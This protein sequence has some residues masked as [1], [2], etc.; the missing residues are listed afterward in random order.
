MFCHGPPVTTVQEGGFMYVSLSSLLPLMV[1]VVAAVTLWQS[2][3]FDWERNANPL[4]L[5]AFRQLTVTNMVLM[6][7]LTVPHVDHQSSLLLFR[8][9]MGVFLCL[10]PPLSAFGWSLVGEKNL[11]AERMLWVLAVAGTFLLVIDGGTIVADHR[12]AL[13][14][15]ETFVP[16]PAYVVFVGVIFAAAALGIRA[17]YLGHKRTVERQ[18]NRFADITRAWTLMASITVL[19]MN[20]L[21]LVNFHVNTI[22][23]T[24]GIALTIQL[25]FSME[26]GRVARATTSMLTLSEQQRGALEQKLTRDELT[27]LYTRN[28]GLTALQRAI[29]EHPAGA[30]VIFLDV[31]DFHSWNAKHGHAT[32]DRVLKGL[33]HVL[34]SSTREVDVCARYA[35][36]EFFVVLPGETAEVAVEVAERIRT[37]LEKM[38][39]PTEEP[40]RASLGVAHAVVGETAA[41][42]VDRADQSALRAKRAGKNRVETEGP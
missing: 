40:V 14:G 6:A 24:W 7:L 8:L 1:L 29:D 12:T 18:S 22:S 19:G 9:S 10:L 13:F 16:G 30:S 15:F 20:E 5:R 21:L 23:T 33:A 42:A 2:Q 37:G 32:G 25:W 3:F 4:V 35:G 41:A 26:V 28:H 31:D 17:I 27:G 11:R 38:R 39:R 34:V 36:D